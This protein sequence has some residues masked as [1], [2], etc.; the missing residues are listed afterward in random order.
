MKIKVLLFVSCIEL[1]AS[2]YYTLTE[3][4]DG[5]TELFIATYIFMGVSLLALI[6]S[7]VLK[8]FI[9]KSSWIPYIFLHCLTCP[10]IFFI[11]CIVVPDYS[12][13]AFES[14]YFYDKELKYD[15][16]INTYMKNFDSTIKTIKM[17]G[18]YHY[19]SV[20]GKYAQEGQKMRLLSKSVTC[21]HTPI[22]KEE[23]M[24]FDSFKEDLYM[25]RDSI[26]GLN[27]K[28]YALE[29]VKGFE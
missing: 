18:H 29:R 21:R 25:D 6:V 3:Y 4:R 17:D 2:L 19:V 14:Y 9:T 7:L 16:R 27:G 28:N 22:C 11:T 20:S 12:K 24:F 15:I 26:Y 10:G 8:S 23:E 5:L 1:I 13:N